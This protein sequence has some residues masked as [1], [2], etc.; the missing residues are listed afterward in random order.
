MKLFTSFLL[1]ILISI[2]ISAQSAASTTGR[3][4]AAKSVEVKLVSENSA[5]TQT[6]KTDALGNYKFENVAD[7][8]YSL[9]YTNSQ[10]K[11]E[12]VSITVRNGQIITLTEEVFV[13]ASGTEQ[14]FDEVSKSVNV[15][16]GQEMRDRADFSLVESLKSIPGFRVQQLGGFGRTASI[17]TRGLRNQDTAILI[18]GVRFRDPTAITGD[19]SPF[20]ADLTLTN[21]DRVE[22][23]RGSGSSVY[24]TNAIGGAVD[25]RTPAPRE[26]FHGQ[27]S[28][29]AGGYGLKRVRGNVSDGNEKI[30]YNLGVSRTLY[31]KGIDGEDDAHNTNFQTRVDYNPFS[32]T[33]LSGRI[34]VGD[35]Y[36]RLNSSPDTI[37]TLPTT[38]RTIIN[39]VPLSV[40]E[41]NRYATGTP[42][43]QLNRGSANF[44]PETNDPDNFQKGK[45][46]SGQLAFTQVLADNLISQTTYQFLQT[47][48]KNIN[49]PRGVGFQPFGG[50]TTSF[51]EGKI[52]TL[53]SHLD[54]TLGKNNLVTIGYEYE[55][56]DFLNRGLAVTA[57]GNFETTA[58]QTSNTV[59]AQDQLN[60]FNR[61]LQLSAAF[62]AQFFDLRKPTF[63]ITNPPYQNLTLQDIPTAY[64][65]D[66]SIAYFFEKTGTKLRGHIGNGYRVP[67]LYER[68]GSSF[69]SFNQAFIPL[70][71]PNLTPERSLG[72]DGGIDQMFFK[73]RAKLSATYFYTKLQNIIGY[74]NIV[75]SIGGVPRSF[76]GYKNVRGGISRGGEFSG[77]VKA[78]SSTKVFASYTYTNSDQLVPQLSGSGVYRTLVVP[79]HQFTLVATQ[80]LFDRLTLNFDYLA[81]SDYL[82]PIFSNTTFVSYLYNFKGAKKGDVTANYEFPLRGE[83]VR[84]KIFGTVENVFDNEYYENGFRAFGVNGRGGVGVSF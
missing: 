40:S 79:N 20:L 55:A 25:F 53:N 56:E 14:N 80:R 33:N 57:A 1:A 61:R 51:F 6:A 74:E 29:V 83:K 77:E 27:L 5:Q 69:S 67:S 21:V 26:G 35:S 13:V 81:T 64:T 43:S 9:V 30:G 37:G 70:G 54:W 48:R 75:T 2:S 12:T 3:L 11:E 4:S 76:G 58:K 38:N 10:G 82:A 71:D 39:A 63:S 84:F 50:S 19:A 28:G 34:F 78:T 31:T 17:K 72:V 47:D 68:F 66:G 73:N 59:Y 16:T 18:D 52:D 8:N 15:I 44:I 23:L 49:G 46:F 32:R 62:R 60:F 65:G 22:V 7:G 41:L 45:F 42:I 36:V 24:G